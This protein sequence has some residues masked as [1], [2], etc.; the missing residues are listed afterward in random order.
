MGPLSRASVLV[1]FVAA[2]A[3]LS[4][5]EVI[6]NKFFDKDGKQFFMKGAFGRPSS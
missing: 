3:A 1:G 5:I 2:A 6:G 4:P